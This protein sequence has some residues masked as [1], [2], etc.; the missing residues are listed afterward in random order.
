MM[1]CHRQLGTFNSVE[2]QQWRSATVP[3]YSSGEVQ[4]CRSTTVP[5]Y[6]SGEVQQCRSTAV[7]KKAG[8]IQN[9][10]TA[11]SEEREITDAN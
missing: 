9:N 11:F 2:V 6:S 5:K 1:A 3:K 8:K 4:Q 7:P 10:L